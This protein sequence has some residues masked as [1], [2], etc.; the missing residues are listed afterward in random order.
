MRK[1]NMGS[2]ERFMRVLTGSLFFIW[3]W[4]AFDTTNLLWGYGLQNTLAAGLVLS[5]IGL[6]VFVTG[7]VSYCPINALLHSN[8]C[9]ACRIGETHS[10]MPV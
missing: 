2:I 4:L 10:H 6:V 8:S 1:H 7:A 5:I 3:S 9:E